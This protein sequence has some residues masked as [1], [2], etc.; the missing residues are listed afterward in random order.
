MV[1]N[2]C[3]KCCERDVDLNQMVHW[4]GVYSANGYR[5]AWYCDKCSAGL[6][7]CPEEFKDP[8]GN[9]VICDHAAQLDAPAKQGPRRHRAIFPNPECVD[10]GKPL[11]DI[12][13]TTREMYFK[14]EVCSGIRQ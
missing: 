10:C 7:E 2:S 9:C 8:D 5:C 12:D 11:P 13:D 1:P 3:D 14:H 6:T 4:P